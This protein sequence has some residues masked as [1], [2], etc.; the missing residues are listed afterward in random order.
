MIK[1]D[2]ITLLLILIFFSGI[3]LRLYNINFDN[4]WYDEIISFWVSS[5]E[6]SFA[7]S[8]KIH[9]EI[10]IAPYTF[11]L[12]LKIYFHLVGYDV[13]N[14]RYIT[15]LFSILT[16]F[17]TLF[18][19]KKLIENNFYLLPIFLVAFNIFLISYSQELRVYSILIFFGSLSLLFFIKLLDTK[20]KNFDASCFFISLLIFSLLHLFSLFL[21]SSFILYLLLIYIK[22]KKSYYLLNLTLSIISLISIFYYSYC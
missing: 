17:T 22:K 20:T 21:I 7:E 6:H 12:F 16:I 3:F 19:S 1:K 10:E 15:A 9:Q 8:F 14:G 11:N 5:P 2:H 13:D 18:I 4:L